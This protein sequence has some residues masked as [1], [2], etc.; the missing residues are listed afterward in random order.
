[1]PELVKLP[2]VGNSQSG[3]ER[4]QFS[5]CRPFARVNGLRPYHR[6]LKPLIG[7][8]EKDRALFVG[9]LVKLIRCRSQSFRDRNVRHSP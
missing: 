6:H 8:L 9:R 5:T 3:R 4:S 1:M 2:V 7:A